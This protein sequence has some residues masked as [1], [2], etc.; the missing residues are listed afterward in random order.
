M[1][2]LLLLSLLFC[3]F[4]FSEANYAANSTIEIAG[5][6]HYS[7]DRQYKNVSKKSFIGRWYEFKNN[8]KVEFSSCTD[9]CGCLRV[10]YSGSWQWKN[11]NV[12]LI[13]YVKIKRDGRPFT[14]MNENRTEKLKIKRIDKNT[15]EITELRSEL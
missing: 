13:N 9:A 14:R 6:W 3:L 11:N 12:L 5:K 10:T 15:L 1:N 4:S 7:S 2:K 8:G